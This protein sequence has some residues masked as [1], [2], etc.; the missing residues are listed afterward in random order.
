MEL[1]ADSLKPQNSPKLNLY[2]ILLETGKI[3]RGFSE[4]YGFQELVQL[5]R[6]WE[7]LIHD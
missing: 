1:E 4:A 7:F 5:Q 3:E 6:I 2:S